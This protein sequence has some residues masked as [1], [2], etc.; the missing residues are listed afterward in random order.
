MV[1]IDEVTAEISEIKGY[2]LRVPIHVVV[3]Y[4]TIAGQVATYEFHTLDDNRARLSSRGNDLEEAC[5]NV[6]RLIAVTFEELDRIP[7][8]ERSIVEEIKM[9]HLKMLLEPE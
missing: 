7:P 2:R 3:G 9:L 6:G 8:G 1:Y 5:Q 4:H